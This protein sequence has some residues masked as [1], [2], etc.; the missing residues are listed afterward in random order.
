M[1]GRLAPVR[2]AQSRAWRLL[3]RLAAEASAA[4]I[5]T[6]DTADRTAP[7]T[8]RAGPARP[9]T[10]RAVGTARPPGYRVAPPRV[11]RVRQPAR[12]PGPVPII[13]VLMGLI[14]TGFGVQYVTG[15]NFLPGFSSGSQPPPRKFPVMEQ[16][17]PTAI[18]IDSLD[19]RARVHR[20]GIAPDGSIAVPP[21]DRYQEAGWYDQSP[22]P[23]QYG[24]AVIVGH[25]DTRTGPAVFHDLAKVRP[26]AEIEVTRTDRSV[27]VF[28]VNSVRRYDKSQ[29]PT[30]EVFDDFNRP[31]LRLITCGGR[32]VGGTTGYADNVVVFASLVSARPA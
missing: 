16:S 27:A 10:G 29:L 9:G 13:I 6:P 30:E 1:A 11:R 21:P 14:I 4:S 2:A 7:G 8:L 3:S 22:T 26:G 24:P 20:V 15:T 28:K 32:W 12:R 31:G 17:P 23:G 25:V 18:A 5:V 19:V